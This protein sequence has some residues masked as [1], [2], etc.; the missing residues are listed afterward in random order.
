MDQGVKRKRKTALLV[1]KIGSYY[2]ALAS[3]EHTAQ[4][5]LASNMWRSACLHLPGVGNWRHVLPHST[6]AWTFWRGNQRKLHELGPTWACFVHLRG[7]WKVTGKGSWVRGGDIGKLA[8][9]SIAPFQS[10][11]EPV[12]NTQQTRMHKQCRKHSRI[13]KRV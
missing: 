4:T 6:E 1:P 7:G 13:G 3:L 9:E 10:W 8:S 12:Y 11:R 5:R 2:V